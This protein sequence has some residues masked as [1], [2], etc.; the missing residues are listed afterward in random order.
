M[1]KKKNKQKSANKL[2]SSGSESSSKTT[3]CYY[4][5]QGYCAKGD[6]CPFL[7]EDA[8][9]SQEQAKQT[10]YS[11]VLNVVDNS[12]FSLSDFDVQ[13]LREIAGR[14]PVYFYSSFA[15]TKGGRRGI[16]NGRDISPEELRYFA[17]SM[18][19]MGEYA[20]YEKIADI[21]A[22]DMLNR[23]KFID[24]NIDKA[25]RYIEIARQRSESEIK[26]FVPPEEVHNNN[27]TGILAIRFLQGDTSVFDELKKRVLQTKTSDEHPA[28]STNSGMHDFAARLGSSGAPTSAFGSSPGSSAAA[29]NIPSNFGSLSLGSS[30]QQQPTSGQVSAFG[31]GAIPPP[32]A[33]NIGSAIFGSSSFGSSPQPQSVSQPSAFGTSQ[34][35]GSAFGTTA[36]TAFYSISSAQQSL[37]KSSLEANARGATTQATMSSFGSFDSTKPASAATFLSQGS[38]SLF[39]SSFSGSRP[40]PTFG[41]SNFGAAPASAVANKP[42]F[43]QTGFS[44]FANASPFASITPSSQEQP[45]PFVTKPEDKTAGNQLKPFSAFSMGSGP[46]FSPFAQVGSKTVS[47][48][49]A[50]AEQQNRGPGSINALDESNSHAFASIGNQSQNNY[51]TE[52]SS[53]EAMSLQMDGVTPSLQQQTQAQQRDESDMGRRQNELTTANASALGGAASV[54]T[55]AETAGPSQGTRF[56]GCY[57]TRAMQ[58]FPITSQE[59][60]NG[61]FPALPPRPRSKIEQMFAYFSQHGRQVLQ[62][63]MSNPNTGHVAFLQSAGESYLPDLSDLNLEEKTAFEENTYELGKVPEIVP[64]LQYM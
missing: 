16:I 29:K 31:M 32:P 18:K 14:P 45:S 50:F 46:G 20:I 56:T 1:T 7:H 19:D 53:V 60:E 24:N 38:S 6:N 63:N 43:G 5:K 3:P 41:S 2:S 61:Y 44:A 23:F 4:Y 42:T 35:G 64:P 33:Q 28:H 51:K 12:D 48:F 34:I 40:T 36:P 49:G 59:T 27:S 11:N 8:D 22:Q 57:T 13:E 21:A 25:E 54:Q 30:Q 58:R 55:K 62:S 47:P 15:V 26:D 37:P 17:Y 10:K 9:K 52:P 39:G